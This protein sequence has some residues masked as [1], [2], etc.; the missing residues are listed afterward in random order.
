MKGRVI[1]YKPVAK[2]S[3][4][5]GAKKG[6]GKWKGYINIQRIPEPRISGEEKKW[7]HPEDWIDELSSSNYSNIEKEFMK[8]YDSLRS[9]NITRGRENYKYFSPTE[10]KPE[11]ID[12]LKNLV[13]EKTLFQR[14]SPKSNNK[15]GVNN[16]GVN[17]TGDNNSGV[18][19]TGGDNNGPLLNI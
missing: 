15:F 9:S 6:G 17:K 12:V 7:S 13:H 3:E 1:K 10:I 4:K 5:T 2:L 14:K 18:K 8:N 11:R 19:K 16:S